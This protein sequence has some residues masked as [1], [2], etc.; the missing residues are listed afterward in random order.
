MYSLLSLGAFPTDL[1]CR[2]FTMAVPG[3]ISGEIQGQT[4]IARLGRLTT[5][6]LH[7]D[8]Q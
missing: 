7:F 3:E 1:F 8:L 4:D 5:L 6:L 2:V